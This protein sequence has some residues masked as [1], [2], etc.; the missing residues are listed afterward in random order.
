M[1]NM[2][3]Q[4]PKLLTYFTGTFHFVSS[5]GIKR[6]LYH[7]WSRESNYHDLDVSRKIRTNPYLE[8]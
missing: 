8:I 5:V 3:R 6:Q 2:Y 1:Q 4:V 7:I